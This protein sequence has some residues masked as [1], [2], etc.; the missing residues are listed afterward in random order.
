M[1]AIFESFIDVG[2]LCVSTIGAS[3]TKEANTSTDSTAPA[4]T[5]KKSLPNTGAKVSSLKPTFNL[6]L[7]SIF[8][9]HIFDLF[10]F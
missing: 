9:K 2:F 4:V 1:F 6:V 5:S 8:Y 10:D 3:K 7:N